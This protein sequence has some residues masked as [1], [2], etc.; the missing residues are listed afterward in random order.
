MVFLT[1]SP[2]FQYQKEKRCST[3]EDP[4]YMEN[5][6]E[7]NLWLAAHRFS[8]WYWKLGGPVKKPP[9]TFWAN[10]DRPR[11]PGVGVFL[12]SDIVYIHISIWKKLA[13]L[14]G[15]L[16]TGG[17]WVCCALNMWR[18]L[19]LFLFQFSNVSE[20]NGWPFSCWQNVDKTF[21]KALTDVVRGQL[22]LCN[23]RKLRHI[24]SLTCNLRT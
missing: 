15:K 7:Q 5:F 13:P 21:K 9:C 12:H 18:S 14:R 23:T 4:F 16:E 22:W 8:F 2:N 1:G 3:N 20:D 24:L 19:I 10:F 11:I 17:A 6:V